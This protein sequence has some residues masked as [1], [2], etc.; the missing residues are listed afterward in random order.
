MDKRIA[1]CA[2]IEGELERLDCY[3]SLA[4][5]LGLLKTS[6][7]VAIEGTGKWQVRVNSNPLDDS[8][9]VILTLAAD[10]G[11]SGWGEQ[12]TL[13]IRCK[14]NTT[15]VFIAWNYYL[16]SVAYVTHRIGD[17]KALTKEWSIS[18]D[19][20]A[21]FYPGSDIALV[22]SMLGHDRFVAQVTPYNE[23]PV[24]AV[25]D[26]RGL[27]EAIKPLQETCGW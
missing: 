4:R 17:A 25:F 9:T 24:T 22:K 21:T 1:E 15:E 6:E 11:K 3:D 7:N 5:E 12:I 18:T 26:I 23:S 20:K 14:S 8:K 27:S 10:E 2:A 13:L 16:G 19:S